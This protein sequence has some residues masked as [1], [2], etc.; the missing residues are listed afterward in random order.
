MEK[1]KIDELKTAFDEIIAAEPFYGTVTH[2]TRA[3][4]ISKWKELMVQKGIKGYPYMDGLIRA[5]TKK[6]ND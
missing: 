4:F 6:A 3:A 1:E 2:R 5:L